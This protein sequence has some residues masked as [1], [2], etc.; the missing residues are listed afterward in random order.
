MVI[1]RLC[2]ISLRAMVFAEV[3]GEVRVFIITTTMHKLDSS[4]I[5]LDPSR[6]RCLRRKR[7]E[8]S[9]CSVVHCCANSYQ[10]YTSLHAIVFSMWIGMCTPS[11][12]GAH[13]QVLQMASSWSDS[14]DCKICC[15]ERSN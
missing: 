12:D 15:F 3:A 2:F 7:A 11:P 4:G 5:T 14:V 10:D 13:M 1:V 6:I 8:I 9:T